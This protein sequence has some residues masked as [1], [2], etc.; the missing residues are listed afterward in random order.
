MSTI[1]EKVLII[2]PS[3][4]CRRV[5]ADYLVGRGY[6]IEAVSNINEAR[7][8]FA[9]ETPDLICADL[10]P[11]L[12]AELAAQTYGHDAQKVPIVVFS[13]AETA[14]EVVDALRSGASDYVIKPLDKLD[15]IDEAIQRVFERI[16]LYRLNQH[17]RQELEDA[18]RELRAGIAELKADHNAG[19]KV[20]IKML[21]DADK[22]IKNVHIDHIIKP[23]LYLS[24]DFLDYSELTDD[25][26]LLYIADVS[27][28]G[29]S[30]AFVTVLLKNLT[31]RLL[32]N[33]RRGSSDDI[34][35]PNRFLQRINTEL[36]ESGLGKHV[37]IFVA[38][39]EYS[40]RK[41][42]YSVAAHFPMPILVHDDGSEFLEGT[43]MAVGLF[44]NLEHQVSERILPKGFKLFMF[45]DGILEVIKA[46]SLDEKENILLETTARGSQTIE[47]LSNALNLHEMNELPD[48]IAILTLCEMAT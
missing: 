48:D 17:F 12:V 14:K 40:T 33:L 1:P 43:G 22:T 18:N 8:A 10:P 46:A 28:H 42:T 25:K 21:P 29:A 19:R 31:N 30:S 24:G 34:L 5:L 38:I 47:S 9:R 2:D 16:R 6:N 39:Y 7:V 11:G 4:R 37:T 32:R 27:G 45:S 3:E 15:Q 44:P 23:S 20:Q 26:L 35:Y 36:L 13:K 41:L